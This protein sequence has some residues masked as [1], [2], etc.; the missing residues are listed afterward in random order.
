VLHI[1]A[2]LLVELAFVLAV[3]A[4]PQTIFSLLEAV[5]G[6]LGRLV[7]QGAFA[8]EAEG[9]LEEDLMRTFVA[10]KGFHGSTGRE[11]GGEGVLTI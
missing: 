10:V 2:A 5:D 7:A 8:I 4:T 3:Q 9:V 6:A 11:V 1:I